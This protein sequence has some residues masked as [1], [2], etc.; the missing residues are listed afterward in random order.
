MANKIDTVTARNKL[1]IR[2]E[3]YWQRIS[4]GFFVGFRKM[5]DSSSG[6]WQF[7]HRDENGNEVE[8]SLGTLDEFK[9]HERF[10]RA[11]AAAREWSSH[12]ATSD[13]DIAPQ[14]IT[15]LD[16]YDAYVKRIQ[17]MK[18]LKP[19]EDLAARYRRWVKPDPIHKIE[20]MKLTRDHLSGF[21][22]R[23]VAKP[24]TVNKAGDT[25]E[26]SK[27]SVNRDMAAV[28]AALNRAFADGK[29]NSDVAWRET[30]KAFK[31]VA[32]R[33]DLYLDREQRRNFINHAPDD[34]AA[35]LRGLSI[36][37]LRPGAL[38]ALTVADFDQRLCVLRIGKDKGGKD[39][40]IKL[41]PEIARIFEMAAANKVATAP[42]LARADGQA[43]NKDSWKD[44]VKDAA[45]NATLPSETSAYTL[46]HSVISD[47][48]HGGLDLLTVAQISG[49]SV[50]MIEKHYGHL[51]S[52][53]AAVA[54]AKLVL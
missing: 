21:R 37:P 28:R 16:A 34:L 51:R 26:R 15:V 25:R 27:D 20:L 35:F 32:K 19:A 22:R 43:W 6:T 40:K 14:T 3:P 2:R 18:G 5:S 10:D 49:T 38:A 12:A 46:R 24:V 17:E 13:A 44:P 39:R 7:R 9:H 47:L 29:V 41:P 53:V 31:N 11:V 48:V 30:L 50:A 4:K 1:K 52:D 36:L 8:S 42:L 23:M 45:K 33:R 54:L